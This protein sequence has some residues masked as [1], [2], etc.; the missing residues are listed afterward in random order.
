MVENLADAR[1]TSSAGWRTALAVVFI[2]GGISYSV[3]VVTGV[4]QQQNRLQAS[5]LAFLSLLLIAAAVAGNPRLLD[6]LRKL[7]LS[8]FE[9]ELARVKETQEAQ[10]QRIDGLD[11]VL[12]L[13]LPEA[14]FKHLRNLLRGKTAYTGNHA[15]RSQLRRLA[16]NRLIE[17]LP[18]AQIADMEDGK[19]FDL[20]QYVRLKPLG[21]YWGRRY[22]DLREAQ[23]SND[24]VGSGESEEGNE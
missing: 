13:L 24:E 17:R 12:P 1:P 19:K 6:S 21:E 18:G 14:E 16:N 10:A 20:A 3:L 15:L 9:L 4:V 23:G 22:H 8:G 5:E 11:M 2:L 7:K